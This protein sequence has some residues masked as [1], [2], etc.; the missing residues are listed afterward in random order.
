MPHVLVDRDHLKRLLDAARILGEHRRAVHGADTK[1]ET[2]ADIIKAHDL[3]DGTVPE[4]N[5]TFDPIRDK[6]GNAVVDK[7]EIVF[8]FG[9]MKIE[10]F[11]PNGDVAKTGKCEPL[12]LN[13]WILKVRI[14]G[15]W[16][17]SVAMKSVEIPKLDYASDDVITLKM[18]SYAYANGEDWLADDRPI[19]PKEGDG[20][21]AGILSGTK[22]ETVTETVTPKAEVVV[23]P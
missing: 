5:H 18:E 9:D 3:P 23:Q 1:E 16:Y 19:N 17:S 20:F 15:K 14:A 21:L 13:N 8:T 22:K 12:R 4:G 2:Y 11:P 10:F 7:Q 6:D